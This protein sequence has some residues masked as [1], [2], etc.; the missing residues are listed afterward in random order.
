VRFNGISGT[1]LVI[2]SDSEIQVEVPSGATTGKIRVTNAV[3]DDT[4]NDDFIVLTA[5]EISGFSPGSGSAGDTITI[6]GSGFTGVSDVRFNGI[7]GTNLVIVSDSEIQVEVPSG[8]TTGKIRVINTAGNDTSDDDFIVLIGSKISSFSPG[9]GSVGDVVTI[10]GSGFTGVSDVRFNGVSGVNLVIVSD[11]EIQVEVPSGATTGKIRVMNVIGN[12]IS[13]D[14]FVIPTAPEI[15]S[16]NPSSGLVGDV[17]TITGSGFAGVSDVRFNGVSGVNLVVVSDSEIQI[18]VPSGATTGKIKVINAVGDDTSSNDFVV[19]T[20]SEISSFSPGSGS[21]GD[22]VTITGTGFTG[23]SDVRFNGVSGV[24]LVIM[25]DSEM[26]VEVPPGATTGKIRVMNTAGNDISHNNFIVVIGP[27]VS[28]FSPSSGPVGQEVTIVGSGFTSVS[29]VT[30]NGTSSLSLTIVSDTQIET[31]VPHGATSGPIHII[32]PD[33]QTVSDDEFTVL[34]PPEIESF[35]P[36][37]GTVGSQVR[38]LGKNLE[39]TTQVSFGEGTTTSIFARSAEEL[40]VVVPENSTTGLIEVTTLAGTVSTVNTF[41][42]DETKMNV[43]LPIILH[44]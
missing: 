4:S 26:Q 7:S 16:F 28:S 29:S 8:A 3:G 19:L 42:V 30:F 14:I 33:S 34:L 5:S 2:V 10:I 21:V 41:T 44:K 17:V 36:D 31:I 11:S 6:T 20:A 40:I 27:K 35:S 12:D 22:L 37:Q 15:D 18:E 24:N 32:S 38:I 39:T 23:V 25:S 1:N 43:Y 13:Q 9:S